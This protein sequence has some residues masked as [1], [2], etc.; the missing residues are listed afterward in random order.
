M[1]TI[2]TTKI[3]YPIQVLTRWTQSPSL[4]PRKRQGESL[5]I[6][7]TVI[8]KK[9]QDEPI[10]CIN[11]NYFSFYCSGFHKKIMRH[12]RRVRKTHTVR[13]QINRIRFRYYI[14][15]GAMKWGITWLIY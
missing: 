4:R 10:P 15:L 2:A 6:N 9:R 7:D 5:Y 13:V 8:F 3:E 11:A 1:V 12:T 14:Y